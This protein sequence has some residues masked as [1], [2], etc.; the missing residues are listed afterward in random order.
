MI[1]VQWHIGTSQEALEKNSRRPVPVSSVLHHHIIMQ[2]VI[3]GN[4]CKIS[5][6]LV[7]HAFG[8]FESNSV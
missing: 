5:P 4:N 6:V 1:S 8:A 3:I 2:T 7:M